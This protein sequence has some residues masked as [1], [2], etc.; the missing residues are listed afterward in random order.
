[1]N[2][3]PPFKHKQKLLRWVQVES[4]LPNEAERHKNAF[5][6]SDT[7]VGDL[8]SWPDLEEERS[9]EKVLKVHIMLLFVPKR[10]DLCEQFSSSGTP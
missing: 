7:C 6:E 10:R 1:M 3:E 2:F 5:L 4:W 9:S 8:A